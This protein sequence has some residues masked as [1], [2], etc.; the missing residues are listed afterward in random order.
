MRKLDFC[1]CENKGAFCFMGSTISLLLQSEISSFDLAF[2]C[3]YTGQFV[4]DLV[5]KPGDRFS[6]IVAHIEADYYEGRLKHIIRT[7]H[8]AKILSRE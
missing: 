2:F 1:L 6:C 5:G 3:D 4:V 8:N 7:D